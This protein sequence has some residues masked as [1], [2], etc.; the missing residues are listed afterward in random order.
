[1]SVPV[2]RPSIHRSVALI[3]FVSSVWVSCWTHLHGRR[4]VSSAST[5]GHACTLY[6]V[7]APMMM[8]M[9]MMMMSIATE[10][11]WCLTP[12]QSRPDV[13]V[14]SL[15]TSGGPDLI[16]GGRCCCVFSDSFAARTPVWAASGPA[17]STSCQRTSRPAHIR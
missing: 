8:M 10:R 6:A 9:M 1:M 14:P 5:N 15:R 11:Q 17:S 3:T 2:V 13:G 7:Y 12:A 16:F 4:E